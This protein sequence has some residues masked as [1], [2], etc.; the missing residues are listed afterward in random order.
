MKALVS[1]G[2]RK[3][4]CDAC[5]ADRLGLRP[6]QVS[7]AGRAGVRDRGFQRFRGRCFGCCTYRTVTAPREDPLLAYELLE[8]QP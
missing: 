3:P 1:I 5:I 4:L 2:D 7:A 8:L 6:E